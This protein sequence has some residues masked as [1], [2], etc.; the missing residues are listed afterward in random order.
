MGKV[1][2]VLE[3]INH[4]KEIHFQRMNTTKQ[5]IFLEVQTS[6]TSEAEI[7]RIKSND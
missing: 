3:V 2:T 1:P 6:V 7:T 5:I 4:E